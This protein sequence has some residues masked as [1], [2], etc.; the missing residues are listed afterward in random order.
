VSAMV[1]L[2]VQIINP[3]D[4]G[5]LPRFVRRT[6]NQGKCPSGLLVCFDKNVEIWR[7]IK[8]INS[9]RLRQSEGISK[10]YRNNEMGANILSGLRSEFEAT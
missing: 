9:F 5:F 10:H 7:S 6:A 2:R 4:Q 3:L 1:V 8:G